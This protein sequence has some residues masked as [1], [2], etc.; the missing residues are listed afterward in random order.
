MVKN[1]TTITTLSKHLDTKTTAHEITAILNDNKPQPSLL[2][3]FTNYHHQTTLPN[4]LNFLQ[5]TLQPNHVITSTTE[6]VLANKIKL[7]NKS[8]I[9]TVTIHLP[10]NSFTPFQINPINGSPTVRNPN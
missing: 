3:V 6:N 4:T 1:P 2:T 5:T 7:E 9:T 8:D 10:N